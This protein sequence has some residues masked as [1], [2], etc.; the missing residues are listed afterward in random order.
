ITLDASQ[1]SPMV[2]YGTNPGMGVPVDARVPDPATHAGADRNAV[3]QAL[4]YM[5][6]RPGQ[7]LL[8]TRIDVVF[9]GS[10][11]NARITDLR[12]AASLLKD[13]RIAPGVRMLVVPGSTQV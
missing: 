6:L 7:A 8:G 5:D 12:L 10:C 4:A 3:E 11:T 2:T 1:L 9:L 13:R